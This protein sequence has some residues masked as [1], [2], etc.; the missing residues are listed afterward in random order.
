MMGKGWV[1]LA[2]WFWPHLTC[3]ASTWPGS[4]K[5]WRAPARFP[6]LT[7]LPGLQPLHIHRG[8]EFISTSV[9]RTSLT[10]VRARTQQQQY[11]LSWHV[12][13]P[14]HMA[15]APF[16]PRGGVPRQRI[17]GV[18]LDSTFVVKPTPKHACPGTLRLTRRQW[19]VHPLRW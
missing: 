6:H 14:Q 2:H 10:H 16:A 8:D 1:F 13:R 19:L 18:P 3:V 7:P 5:S 11:S 9:Y 4:L 17:W 15:V 12:S